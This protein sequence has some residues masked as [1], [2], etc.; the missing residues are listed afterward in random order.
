MNIRLIIGVGLTAVLLCGCEMLLI[1]EKISEQVSGPVR[2][3]I[4]GTAYDVE[5]EIPLDSVKVSLT[6]RKVDPIMGCC[7]QNQTIK[8]VY[9]DTRGDYAIEVDIRGG[10]CFLDSFAL[11]ATKAISDSLEYR[12]TNISRTGNFMESVILVPCSE[13]PREI[14][15]EMKI[16][17]KRFW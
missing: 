14:D 16:K 6:Q 7:T 4:T 5:E 8:T 12:L 1:P 3:V 17:E 15:L 2:F 10:A 13:H 9:T 11:S